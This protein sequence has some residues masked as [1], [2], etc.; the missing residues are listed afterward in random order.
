MRGPPQE[1]IKY[2]VGRVCPIVLLMQAVLETIFW[3]VNL[4]IGDLMKDGRSSKAALDEPI[5]RDP[6]L[7][8][9]VRGRQP[10]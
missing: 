1:E 2:K 3:G 9:G 7:A 10:H 5:R 8:T 4:F 6:T